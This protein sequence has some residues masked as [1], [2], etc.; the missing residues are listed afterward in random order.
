MISSSYIMHHSKIKDPAQSE[1]LIEMI[2]AAKKYQ[3]EM[4]PKGEET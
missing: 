1:Q 4:V 2:K 3:I